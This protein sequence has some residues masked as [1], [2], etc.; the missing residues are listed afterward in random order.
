MAGILRLHVLSF[1]RQIQLVS[2]KSRKQYPFIT[3]PPSH[4]FFQVN[5]KGLLL[6]SETRN[7]Y[8]YYS[9]NSRVSFIHFPV[10][11]FSGLVT[12]LKHAFITCSRDLGCT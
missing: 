11:D 3:E 5:M 6:C 2:N 1:Y 12:T 8:I 7:Y 10:K 9:S 4:N